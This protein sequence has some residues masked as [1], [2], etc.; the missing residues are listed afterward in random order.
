MPKTRNYGR[1]LYRQSQVTCLS[2]HLHLREQN[3]YKSFCER[4]TRMRCR[5]AAAWS[6][7]SKLGDKRVN[8]TLA[9]KL[10]RVCQRQCRFQIRLNPC[11]H[12]GSALAQPAALMARNAPKLTIARPRILG[13]L[14]LIIRSYGSATRLG[15]SE[16]LN[17][18]TPC[19]D[20]VLTSA[21]IVAN[22]WG[23]AI[24][25][26]RTTASDLLTIG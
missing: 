13:L 1:P 22:S 15:C 6:H 4:G 18:S 23:I 11:G 21:S 9:Q 2:T 7:L 26:P 24:P 10:L 25:S 19:T 8:E 12:C 14:R 5:R 3:A 17:F 16:S 20:R